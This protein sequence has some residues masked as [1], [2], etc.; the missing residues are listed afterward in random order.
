MQEWARAKDPEEVIDYTVEW[1]NPDNLSAVAT[2]ERVEPAED[3]VTLTITDVDTDNTNL[4]RAITEL[5]FTGGT[6]GARCT[7]KLEADDDHGSPRDRKLIGRVVLVI[8][9]R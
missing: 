4:P 1:D 8:R 2:V 6:D 3:P 5:W 9:E 7:I